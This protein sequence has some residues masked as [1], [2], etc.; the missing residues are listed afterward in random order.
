MDKKETKWNISQENS[1][2]ES[3]FFDIFAFVY[4]Q[5]IFVSS[6]KLN[7][8]NE[9]WWVEFDRYDMQ[10]HVPSKRVLMRCKTTRT[11]LNIQKPSSKNIYL[12]IY[13]IIIS[14]MSDYIERRFS[15]ISVH[16]SKLKNTDMHWFIQT[17]FFTFAIFIPFR[18]L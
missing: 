14:S 2:Q 13:L 1:Y 16:C 4:M 9:Y 8:Y 11:S 7:E 15:C 6:P 12:C 5:D 10:V 3:V 18:P 17:N